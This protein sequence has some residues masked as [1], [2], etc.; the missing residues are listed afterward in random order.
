[1]NVRKFYI[2]ISEPLYFDVC[3]QLNSK[4]DFIHQRR[5]FGINVLIYV[6]AGTL[7]INSAGRD[8]EINPGQYIILRAGEEH[9][10]TKPSEE[11]LSYFWAHFIPNGGIKSDENNCDNYRDNKSCYEIPEYGELNSS[12]MI[13]TMIK[14]FL[15]MSTE[16]NGGKGRM[17]DYMMSLMLMEVSCQSVMRDEEL[18]NGIN[19]IIYSACDWIK[20]NYSK[21]FRVS[22]LAAMFGYQPDY[23]SSIF[24]KN[25]GTS[26]T[27]YTNKIRIRAAELMLSNPEISIREAAYSCGFPDEKYFMKVFKKYK[28]ITPTEYRQKLWL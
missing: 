27:E 7:Y 19:P 8:Y 2:D 6:S 16:E 13:S 24:K 12:S 1:M 11:E 21:N 26:L 3:G 18:K 28:K 23:F 9:F 25:V 20:S 10:G 22:E 14:R 4:R 15:A 17:A 5:C